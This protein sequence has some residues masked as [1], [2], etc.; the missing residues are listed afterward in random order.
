MK[1]FIVKVIAFALIFAI[2]AA[3]I[4]AVIDPYNVF[5]PLN[6]RDNGIEPNKNYVK[7]VYL[8]SE[9]P[10]KFDTF[11]LGSS[12]VGFLNPAKLEGVRAYNLTGSAGLPREQVDNLK[13]MLQNGIV[14]E[15][16]IIEV[17][18]ISA[19]S[20]YRSH[21]DKHLRA[22]YEYLKSHPLQFVKLYFCPSVAVKSLRIS[23]DHE[24]SRQ[25]E[26]DFY[27]YGITVTYGERGKYSPPTHY[28]A[29]P[30]DYI[31]DAL[32]AM[33]E[34]T[35]LCTQYDI[36]L[37]VFVTPIYYANFAADLQD[38]RY[39]DFLRGLSE[40]TPFYNFSG[41]ND[42]TVDRNNYMDRSHFLAE[43][44]DMIIDCI[45]NGKTDPKLL[46][47]GFGFYTDSGNIE[48][49]IEIIESNKGL[50]PPAA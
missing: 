22:P 37:T 27:N 17:D 50:C 41:F 40:I 3:A 46:S 42:V 11:L 48:E 49:L 30:L 36:D 8:L 45:W 29:E 26:E 24:P 21:Y 43:V 12:R 10:D 15:N 6:I 18:D 7:M 9:A 35:E 31:D 14:P 13:T 4:S 39:Y 19:G 20:D 2:A 47:Q 16:I 28:F 34:L 44:G 38:G 33:K 1:K 25:V 32:A 23:R 5:H